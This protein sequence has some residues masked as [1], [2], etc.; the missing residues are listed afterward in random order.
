MKRTLYPQIVCVHTP[1]SG[2]G[3]NGCFRAFW[4][5]LRVVGVGFARL[6]IEVAWMGI[7]IAWLGIGIAWLGIDWIEIGFVAQFVGMEAT[8]AAG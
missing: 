3:R 6:G 1:V 7:G 5:G 2:N 4:T 8:Q